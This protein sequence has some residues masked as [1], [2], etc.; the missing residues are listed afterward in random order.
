MK[1]RTAFLAFL[2]ALM[3]SAFSACDS[4][5]GP[6]EEFGEQVDETTEEV[7]EEYEQTKE[8]LE[9]SAEDDD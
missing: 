7:E 4:N 5:D 6:A 8:D 1:T 2:A 9:D 3:I